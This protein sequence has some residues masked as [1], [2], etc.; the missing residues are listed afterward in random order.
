[1]TNWDAI[2]A[3]CGDDTEDWP[4]HRIELYPTTTPLRGE[5]KDCIRIRPPRQKDL[6]QQPK[7]K[8]LTPP[9]DDMDDDIPF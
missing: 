5:I 4:G 7:A 6:P 8:P 3:I 2:A 9:A 1:M